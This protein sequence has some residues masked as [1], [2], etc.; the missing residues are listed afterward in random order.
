MN[1]TYK[2]FIK[3]YINNN[4]NLYRWYMFIL[5]YFLLKFFFGIE[6]YIIYIFVIAL[7]IFGISFEYGALTFFLI[8]MIVYIF[9]LPVEANHYMSFVYGFMVLSLF[10]NFYIIFK[11]RFKQ[12][13][14]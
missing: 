7:I 14:D 1:K 8:S 2:K 6:Y 12:K 10:K 11:E 13:S 3:K 4:Q 9:G 5:Y